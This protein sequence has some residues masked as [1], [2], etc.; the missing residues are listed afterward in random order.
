MNYN[1]AC[2]LLELKNKFT[3]VELKKAYYK[4]ALLL[5]PDKNPKTE[6]EFKEISRAYQFLQEN[7]TVD[8][9]KLSY[10]ELIKKIFNMDLLIFKQPMEII[11]Q[12]DFSLKVFEKLRK[13][14]AIKIFKLIHK[15]NDILGFTEETLN[16]MKNI[17]QKKMENDNIIILNPTI[18]DLLED[19]VY[20]FKGKTKTFFCPLW[21]NE[22]YFD[23]SGNDII[24]RCEPE[25]PEN[26]QI[27]QENIISIKITSTIQKLFNDKKLT[28]Y[29]GKREFIIH[30]NFLRILKY[31]TYIFP[32]LGILKKDPN[33]ILNTSCRTDIYVHLQLL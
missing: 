6:E 7:K 5:H 4:K 31:Q 9:S 11:F 1:K 32:N 33:D 26:I 21:H 16:K 30:S 3:Q 27:N 17:I 13:E 20:K 14:L 22:L 2:A 29:I 10:S 12:K 8:I 23:D 19:K 15:Y 24:I 25:L 18:D 28:F